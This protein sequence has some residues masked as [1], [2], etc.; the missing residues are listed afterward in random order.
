MFVFN[1]KYN[2]SSIL[3]FLACPIKFC[4]RSTGNSCVS[5]PF[6]A[7][8]LH[9]RGRPELGS[10][11]GVHIHDLQFLYEEFAVAHESPTCGHELV[12]VVVVLPI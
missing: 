9:R 5:G 1:R 7:A 3:Q 2:F 8:Q 11:L 10:D 12:V 4:M 6:L